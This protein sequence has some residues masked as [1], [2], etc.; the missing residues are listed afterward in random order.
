MLF[1]SI[2]LSMFCDDC[3]LGCFSTIGESYF[4]SFCGFVV[5]F[6]GSLLRLLGTRMTTKWLTDDADSWVLLECKIQQQGCFC[7]QQKWGC[8]WS[9]YTQNKS[10][11]PILSIKSSIFT[12]ALHS[13]KGALCYLSCSWILCLRNQSTADIGT[14]G[15]HLY[16]LQMM[17]CF[18]L[19]RTITCD[20]HKSKLLH[21]CCFQPLPMVMSF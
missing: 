18:W 11:L 13:D 10:F 19:H 16:Y 5:F 20:V 7:L 8:W 14:L 17:L 2:L 6:H 21:F 3:R 12:A 9:R 1:L 15:W 4:N